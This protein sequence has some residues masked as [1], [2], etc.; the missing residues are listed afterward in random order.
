MPGGGMPGG[1]MP[2]RICGARRPG[3]ASAG[4]LPQH[5]GQQAGRP[6]PAGRA[7]SARAGRQGGVAAHP[8]R[9]HHGRHA[10]PR[11]HHAHGRRR[12][13]RPGRAHR[14]HACMA[15]MR[16][17]QSQ[18]GAH[19]IPGGAVQRRIGAALRHPQV[20]QH[21]AQGPAA[22]H[23]PGG[24]IGGMP[25]GRIIGGA[26]MLGRGSIMP[27]E[28]PPTPLAGPARPAGACP[29]AGT[30]MPLPAAMP[31]PGPACGGG[32]AAG[33]RAGSTCC[34]RCSRPCPA[35]GCAA[36]PRRS[37]RARRARRR[38]PAEQVAAQPGSSCAA[39]Q[40]A[41]QAAHRRQLRLVHALVV[42]R[43]WALDCERQ[44]LLAA[45]QH[46]PQHAALL[47]LRGG[48]GA[49]GC[50]QL[51]SSQ[52]RRRAGGGAQSASAARGRGRRAGRP[53]AHLLLGLALLRRHLAVLLRVAQHQ[54][55]VPVKRHEPAAMAGRG[56]ARGAA[57]AR[58]GRAPAAAE[59]PS[60][61]HDLPAIDDRDPHTCDQRGQPV[62]GAARALRGRPGPAP[63]A[64]AAAGGG[65]PPRAG[66]GGRGGAAGAGIVLTIVN[67]LQQ[68]ACP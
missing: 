26:C 29:G 1:G 14:R 27:G 32:G 42:R 11:R 17:A 55:H 57:R 68:F 52:A 8:G 23:S 38:R 5:H 36:G 16:G 10:G 4:A 64:A 15:G 21:G 58:I 53:A 34:S 66:P 9:R 31:L 67:E 2:G 54:V 41:G 19:R 3:E 25:G 33:E 63:A 51:A 59:L 12:H 35:A 46:Q 7:D 30:G 6:R 48:R 60:P 45:Q 28:G 40:P 47:P 62:S 49:A 61:A 37:G 20:R 65:D 22:P 44:H 50:R 43:R 24:I 56:V 13:A 39:S 18:E